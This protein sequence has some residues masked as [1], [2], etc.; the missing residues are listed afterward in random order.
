MNMKKLL[1]SVV[2]ACSLVTGVPSQGQKNRRAGVLV[3]SN[4]PA[5]FISFLRTTD[6][7]P[8]GT[9][10]GRKHLLFR[11][12][13]NTQWAI[14]LE[15]SGVPKEYGDA[16]LFYTIE[17]KDKGEIQ[18]DSRC[19]VCSVNPVGAGRSVIFSI[20]ADY[21]SQDRRLRI[22]YSF[23]WERDNETDGGSYSIHSVTF[24]FSYL[25]NSALPTTVPSNN[26]F[27]PTPR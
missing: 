17:D 23:A 4:K 25:P 19:H 15:M 3:N 26:S 8:L 14:W 21:A 7:E 1:L 22:T 12:T 16:A 10:Y 27:N 6:L 2:I 18:I 13:N 24:Y 5:V 9:G 20:P 11:I